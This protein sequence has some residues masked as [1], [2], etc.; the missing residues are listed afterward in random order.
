MSGGKHGLLVSQLAKDTGVAE[1]DVA[2]LLKTLGGDSVL[3]EV[4]KA[5]G[6]DKLAALT[7]GDLKLAVRLGRSSVAV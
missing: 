2:K 4:E 6:K 1:A 5:V 7:V 3:G